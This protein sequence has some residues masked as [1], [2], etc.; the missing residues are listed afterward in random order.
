MRN[1][2]LF[3]QLQ[4]NAQKRGT[5]FFSLK[6][7]TPERQEQEEVTDIKTTARIIYLVSAQR[8]RIRTVQRNN[9][10]LHLSHKNGTAHSFLSGSFSML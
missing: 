9:T 6:N 1:S 5:D 10:H 8:T 2:F 3:P 7:T 4:K